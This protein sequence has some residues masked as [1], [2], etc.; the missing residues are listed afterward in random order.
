M[1]Q[2]LIVAFLLKKVTGELGPPCDV[3]CY[4][5]RILSVLVN[6]KLELN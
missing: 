2:V 3:V 4:K 6:C 5:I 1:V